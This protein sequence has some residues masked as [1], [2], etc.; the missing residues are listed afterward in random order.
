MT[1]KKDLN[2]VT[3]HYL[4]EIN[5]IL[6]FVRSTEKSLTRKQSRRPKNINKDR[7]VKELEGMIEFI[8]KEDETKK[9]GRSYR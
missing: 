7:D 8:Q 3:D 9:A 5:N 2:H 1:L 6:D 4:S